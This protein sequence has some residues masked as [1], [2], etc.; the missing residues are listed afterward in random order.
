M[1]THHIISQLLKFNKYKIAHNNDFFIVESERDVPQTS[2][3]A[4]VIL[5]V[6]GVKIK[7]PGEI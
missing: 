1:A 3:P 2:M 6:K 5:S 4:S 7:V